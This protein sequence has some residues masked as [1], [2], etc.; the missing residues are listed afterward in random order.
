METGLLIIRLVVG[1]TVASHGAQKL[2]GS[3][4]GYGIAGTGA[5][6][7]SLG[8][9]PGRL[10]ATTAGLGEAGGGLALALGLFTPFASAAIMATMLVAILSVHVEKGFY[11]Q[12]GG[13]EYNLTI[14][15]VAAGLA[16]TGPGKVSL[17]GLIGLSLAGTP[18]GL[19]AIGLAGLGGL[20]PLLMRAAS[21]HVT[22]A[23]R[24]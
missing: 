22:R 5:Y 11:A 2:F 10:F 1:L 3:F 18:W 12:G 24:S 8:F 14:A 4:G 7:E 15:A 19:A 20:P 9:R 13:Y 23:A 21:T 17:D 6:F 16:F